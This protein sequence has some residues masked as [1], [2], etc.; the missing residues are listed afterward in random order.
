MEQLYTVHLKKLAWAPFQGG[1]KVEDG[2]KQSVTL[3]ICHTALHD[4]SL[5]YLD[6]T[7]RSTAPVSMAFVPCFLSYA[8]FSFH[9]PAL[10]IKAAWLSS[11]FHWRVRLHYLM[12]FPCSIHLHSAAQIKGQRGIHQ[13][14]LF[15]KRKRRRGSRYKR[16]SSEQIRWLSNIGRKDKQRQSGRNECEIGREYSGFRRGLGIMC[17]LFHLLLFDESGN[18]QQWN[19]GTEIYRL[20]G[21]TWYLYH[22][23][24][25]KPLKKLQSLPL[26]VHSSS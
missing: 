17:I 20:H 5:S 2:R 7:K 9:A 10:L 3:S 25:Q 15:K 19:Y 1:Q 13:K 18:V 21:T 14:E 8:G 16:C 22:V 12:C 4:T 23:V 11:E 26:N 24:V 6:K